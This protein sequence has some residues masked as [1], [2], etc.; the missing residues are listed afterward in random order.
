MEHSHITYEGRPL[1]PAAEATLL[2]AGEQWPPLR[3][4]VFRAVQDAERPATAY[5]VAD[6]VGR[7]QSR[8][9][10]AN[11]VYRILDV[12]V[13]TNLVRKIESNNTFVVNTHPACEHDCIFLICEKCGRVS[14]VDADTLTRGLR[15]TVEE[16]GFVSKRA[17]LEM[18]GL[19]ADCAAA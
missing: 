1:V 9:I 2:H 6:A 3:A 15:G 16:S 18:Q 19:C 4:A 13:A 7:A 17:V 14:H 11:S 8:R 10:A 12:F 5:D